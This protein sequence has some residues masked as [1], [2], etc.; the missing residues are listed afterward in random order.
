MKPFRWTA[1]TL[2]P[3]ATSFSEKGWNPAGF[4]SV[5]FAAGFASPGGCAGFVRSSGGSSSPPPFGASFFGGWER[6]ES[7]LVFRGERGR[8][9]GDDAGDRDEES[10]SQVRGLD[11]S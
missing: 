11:A 7:G 2:S 8:G 4:S 6:I 1:F 5:A 10:H 3:S 9:H